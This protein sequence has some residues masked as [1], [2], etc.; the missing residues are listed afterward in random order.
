MPNYYAR[1][2]NA[3]IRARLSKRRSY[4]KR[5]YRKRSY[6]RRSTHK[7]MIGIWYNKL[8][9][10]VY[11]AR[12]KFKVMH[13]YAK[14][15]LQNMLNNH[16]QQNQHVV[17]TIGNV[18]TDEI[19][20]IQQ[21]RKITINRQQYKHAMNHILSVM[22]EKNWY[23]L[24]YAYKNHKITTEAAHILE[25]GEDHHVANNIESK[26]LG[27]VGSSVRKIE[28]GVVGKLK[29][30]GGGGLSSLMMIA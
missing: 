13:T 17:Q 30:L 12:H 28:S 9:A 27:G 14:L 19:K 11:V 23:S 29:A 10:K 3:R 1:R 22:I 7:G 16:T 8:G 4:R 15:I 5:S 26:L 20:Q 18:T 6:R 21:H 25:H 2:N 24:W